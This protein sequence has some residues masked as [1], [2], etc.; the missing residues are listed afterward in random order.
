MHEVQRLQNE[1]ALGI[2]NGSFSDTL[3]AVVKR[4]TTRKMIARGSESMI[5]RRYYYCIILDLQHM[6]HKSNAVTTEVL[7]FTV[8]VSTLTQ[9][10]M[11]I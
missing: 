6:L 2:Q 1:R 8:I 9:N 10:A 4:I 11:D 5:I 3:L 7:S